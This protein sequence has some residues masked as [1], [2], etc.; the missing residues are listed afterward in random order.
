MIL[1]KKTIR[2][3]LRHKKAYISCI[4]LM[5]LGVWAYT[6]MNT[7]LYEIENGKNDY[8]SENRLGEAFATV[9][10]IP[11]SS[12]Q[13]LNEIEGIKQVDG[14]VIQNL[15]VV[16]PDNLDEVIRLRVISTVIGENNRRLNAYVQTGNDLTS[17]KDILIGYDFYNAYGYEP[18][19]SIT[20]LVNQKT[21]DF[22]VSGYVYS[23]EY[24]Y[25]VENQN[26]FFSDTTKFNVAYVDE[27]LL[28]TLL[29]MEGVYNDLS[30]T[31][32]EGYTYDD[33]KDE[34]ETELN[35]YGLIALYERDDLFSYMMLE[36]EIRGGRSMSTTIPMTFVGMA[37]IVL[38]LMLK[39][40]IEQERTQIGTMKAFGYSNRTVLLHYIS[41]G[42]ITG[43]I[44]AIVGLTISA[45]TISPYIQFYLDYYK[46]PIGTSV[47]NFKYYYI[48]GFWSIV[49]GIIGAYFGAKK[50]VQLNPAEAMRPKA[51]PPVKK[52]ITHAI[53]FLKTI[54]NSRG[55]MTVRNISRNKVRSSFVI[56]GI[57]FSYSMMVMIGMMS[58]L[59]DTM[60]FNQFTHVLK[61]DAEIALGQM[62]PYDEGIQSAT[63]MDSIPYAEGLLKIPA[64]LKNGY[65]KEGTVIVGIKEGN[66]NYK[67]YDDVRNINIQLDKEGIVLG[68][69]LAD[70]LNVQKGDYVYVESP[71]LD[72]DQKLYISDI[73][74]QNLG[75]SAYIDLA[76]LSDLMDQDLMINSLIIDSMATSDI[77]QELIA[78]DVVTKIEDKEKTLELYETLLG[79]YDF[80]ILILQ[81]IAIIIGFTIIYNTAVISMSERSREYAT[82]R[83]LGLTINEVKE[84][85]SLEYWLLSFIGMALG[86]PFALFLNTSLINS[87][88]VDAFSWPATIPG[89]AYI[90]GAIGCILAVAF[91]NMTSVKA[92][93]KLDLVEVLKE[94][95]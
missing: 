61:Y 69:L 92:I 86:V 84:I 20:L 15:R 91:S 28:M 56:L 14:R 48:G 60:F 26:E 53:P 13:M 41:Y 64:L 63:S 66:H 49:G 10:Q 17:T 35:A 2:S 52:D 59:V 1:L 75:S 39:R 93:K 76:Y 30:F 57:M 83:V 19:D 74:N 82:L 90:I 71:Y 47:T 79:S 21:Y 37:A 36:E 67:V 11:K 6:T 50:V 65:E 95:E 38:Y 46:M 87:I 44:G 24:V 54:L 94:R 89:Y 18:G 5:A 78:S 77:R 73:V 68:S 32:E 27:N 33:V 80:I 9:A 40:I 51:P 16:L 12:L 70:L 45:L 8:Y 43:L 58:G 34:L 88:D 3:M 81:M 22:N 7:A 62:V 4:I 25:I 31:F 85:M 42:F 55:I 72:N 29:G 23:P